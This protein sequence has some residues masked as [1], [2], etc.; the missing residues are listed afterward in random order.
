MVYCIVM[1]R[2]YSSAPCLP[3]QGRQFHVNHVLDSLAAPKPAGEIC[4]LPRTLAIHCR[5]PVS[6]PGLWGGE[7]GGDDKMA[8]EHTHG[9]IGHRFH[10]PG[11][12]EQWTPRILLL[13]TPADSKRHAKEKS[14]KRKKKRKRRWTLNPDCPT[15]ARLCT[16]W[17]PRQGSKARSLFAGKKT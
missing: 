3:T 17:T 2:E 12:A 13:R 1:A 15:H 9:G 4:R 8:L 7:N 14:K 10:V 11:L 6:S 5:P 16:E